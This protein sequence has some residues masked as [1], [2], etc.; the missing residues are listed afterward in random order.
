MVE[1]KSVAKA[2]GIAALVA[3]AVWFFRKKTDGVVT[4]IGIISP[5]GT[6]SEGT[7][8]APG[9]IVA[10]DGTV[11]TPDDLENA[12]IV[13]PEGPPLEDVG[14]MPPESLPVLPP[15]L[16]PITIPKTQQELC[17]EEV[18]RRFGPAGGNEPQWVINGLKQGLDNYNTAYYAYKAFL[19]AGWN[20]KTKGAPEIAQQSYNITEDVFEAQLMSYGMGNIAITFIRKYYPELIYPG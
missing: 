11:V 8:V 19:D 7:P 5:G 4:P 12:G 6:D 20:G 16:A 9:D 18:Y 2:I 17:W 1:K 13:P 3:L 14:T 10:P 15:E